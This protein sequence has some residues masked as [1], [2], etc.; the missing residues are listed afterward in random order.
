MP[1]NCRVPA[2]VGPPSCGPALAQPYVRVV[3]VATVLRLLRSDGWVLVTQRGSRRQFK[4]LSKP[5]RV[6]VPGRPSH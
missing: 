1:G 6:T 3:K 4:H 2:G 5:G